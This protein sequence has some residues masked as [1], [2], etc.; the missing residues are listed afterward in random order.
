MPANIVLNPSLTT[1]GNGLFDG[2]SSDGLV[3]GNAYPDPAIRYQLRT[4]ILS[5]AETLPMWGGVGIYQFVPGGAGNPSYGLGPIVGRATGLTGAYP[6]VA[7]SVFESA[8]GM[9]NTPQSPVPTAGAFGQVNSY[10]LGSGMRIAVACDPGLVSLRGL[11]INSE[12]AWD[13]VNQQLIPYVGATAVSSGTYNSTTG[14]VT[15]TMASAVDLSPGDT[16]VI[17]GVTGTGS[18]ADVDGT[19]TAGA[20][21]T[22]STVTYTIATGL[23]LTITGG[24]LT[25]GSPLDVDVL[26]I[27]SGNSM[28]VSYS[29][30][31]GFTT[32]NYSGSAALIQI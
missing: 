25:T 3:Q 29:S 32:W 17:S 31:T 13:F 8:Y 9:V 2:A 24:S 15:L 23:T 19:Y 12:V 14:L 4:G 21:T 27:S 26:D 18:F 7:F 11:S 10:R 1:V 6:L 20:G 30:I 28:T 16:V 22:G 5:S